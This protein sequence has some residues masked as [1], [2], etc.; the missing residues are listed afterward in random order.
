MGNVIFLGDIATVAL[1]VAEF[2]T[3]NF[4]L[5]QETVGTSYMVNRKYHLTSQ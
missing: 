4:P 2:V 3:F 1:Q 5:K